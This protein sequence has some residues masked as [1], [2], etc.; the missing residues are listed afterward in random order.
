M[1]QTDGRGIVSVLVIRGLVVN[2]CGNRLLLGLIV[3][4]T[5]LPCVAADCAK[6]NPDWQNLAAY[7]GKNAE[8]HA[9]R[10]ES[11]RVVF[12]GDSITESWGATKSN[13]FLLRGFINRGISG[14][15]TPQMLL[16]FRADVIDLKPKIVV[17]LAGTNDI[18]GNTGPATQ[19]MIAGN[20]ASMAE[21]ARAHGIRV[22]LGSVLPA[23]AFPW[24]PHVRPATRIVELNRWIRRYAEENRFSYIDYHGAMAD[25]QMGMRKEYS[26][27]GVHPNAAGYTVMN[28]IT[29]RALE[30]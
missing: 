19:E 7:R 21:L 22:M 28:Q 23:A 20:I 4:M 12:M 1:Y 30:M 3:V 24:A 13:P 14:Q 29:S 6:P 8:L 5:S 10:T 2:M 9:K 25:A 18:A 17:I 26:D 11:S 16:R 15:T 27:D